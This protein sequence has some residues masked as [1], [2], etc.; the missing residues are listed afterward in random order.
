MHLRWS[1]ALGLGMGWH[2]VGFRVW[3]ISERGGR[4]RWE[5]QQDNGFLAID[6]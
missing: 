3:Q 6:E 4:L 2:T 5:A 1:L